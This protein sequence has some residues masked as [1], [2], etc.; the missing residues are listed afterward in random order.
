MSCADTAFRSMWQEFEWENKVTINTNITYVFVL[1]CLLLL[2]LSCFF[3]W[4]LLL[5]VHVLFLSDWLW[6]TVTRVSF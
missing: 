1:C 4:R 3:G 2:W 6:R 5:S